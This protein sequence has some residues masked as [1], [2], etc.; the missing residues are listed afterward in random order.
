MSDQNSDFGA[1]L[2]GFIVGGFV[3]AAVALLMAP[4]SG[5]ETRVLIRDRSIE[6]KDR[7]VEAAEDARIRAE[8]AAE[9]ARMRADEL[10]RRGQEIYVEQKG[11]LE[12]AIDATKEAS[13]EPSESEDQ[14]AEEASEA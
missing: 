9:E 4:Q 10:K 13:V 6:L 8:A 7:A 3:G 5:E 14:S 1:F 2:S 11:R 12:T